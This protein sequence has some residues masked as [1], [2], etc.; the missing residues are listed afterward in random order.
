MFAPFQ[1]TAFIVLDK[2]IEYLGQHLIVSIKHLVH[3][4]FTI[5]PSSFNKANHAHQL[6]FTAACR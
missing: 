3:N 1:G 4:F 6:M 5:N 2:I